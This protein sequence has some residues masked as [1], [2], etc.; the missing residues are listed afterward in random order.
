MF[1]RKF[2]IT[3]LFLLFLSA[4][5]EAQEQGRTRFSCHMVS[6]AT[7]LTMVTGC[8]VV[9]GM[10]YF[11]TDIVMA[12]SVISTAANYFILSSGTGTACGSTNTARYGAM[13]LA[14]TTESAQFATPIVTGSAEMLCFIHAAVGTKD[15]TINGYLAP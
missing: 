14:F 5:V 15:F 6:T 2:S 13:S 4:S 3:V 10:R 8:D 7:A 9:A 1:F 11:I 12:S